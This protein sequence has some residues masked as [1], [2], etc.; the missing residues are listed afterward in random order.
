MSYEEFKSQIVEILLKNEEFNNYRI[1]IVEEGYNADDAKKKHFWY[2][3]TVAEFEDWLYN[4]N[5]SLF[6][7]KSDKL[8]GDVLIISD[9]NGRVIRFQMKSMYN[10]FVKNGDLDVES[11]YKIVH[12]QMTL[13]STSKL[14][15][16]K[17]HSRE[18]DK[19]KSI[20][21]VR[22][23]DYESNKE[24]LKEY[25]YRVE[26]DIALVL[27]FD[28]TDPLNLSIVL[29]AKVPKSHLDDWGMTEEEVIDEALVN[30]HVLQQPRLFNAS[31]MHSYTYKPCVSR[32]GAFMAINI[33]PA[34][35]EYNTEDLLLLTTTQKTNGAVALYYAGVKEKMA[36]IVGSD[37]YIYFADTGYVYI[38][39]TNAD[40]EKLKKMIYINES[41][42]ESN[43]DADS[44]NAAAK[45][46]GYIYKYDRV[47]KKVLTVEKI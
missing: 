37:Y 45:Y 17:E 15:L 43:D 18:Y 29:S 36:E 25:I 12:E 30:T 5:L 40:I 6:Q 13:L 32:E 46:L 35:Y 44:K 22:P 4:A 20:L 7:G 1:E 8:L 19:V 47:T 31:D 42:N 16:M 33:N 3:N 21:I 9:K 14:D 23:L 28:M 38:L 34:D 27:Y 11:V 39:S 41:E 26:N 2:T 24:Q 10:E